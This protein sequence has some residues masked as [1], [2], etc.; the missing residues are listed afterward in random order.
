M[1]LGWAC[2]EDFFF[3]DM[4]RHLWRRLGLL[5]W[6]TKSSLHGIRLNLRFQKSAK[7]SP[8]QTIETRSKTTPSPCFQPR[9]NSDRVK[10]IDFHVLIILTVHLHQ[11]ASRQDRCSTFNYY[12]FA[13][14]EGAVSTLHHQTLVYPS[15]V[16]QEIFEVDWGVVRGQIHSFGHWHLEFILEPCDGG[17]VLGANALQRES[18]S[19][20]GQ[21]LGGGLHWEWI[22][23]ERTLNSDERC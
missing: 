19:C 15:I 16:S 14:F 9:N 5:L 21:V 7:T 11:V 13:V 4:F 1:L 22:C 3:V 2:V 20:N 10:Y 8:L 23:A 18:L 6:H 17:C 12:H